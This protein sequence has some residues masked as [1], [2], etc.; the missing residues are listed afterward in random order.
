LNIR[1]A[2]VEN[3]PLA[4]GRAILRTN[5]TLTLYMAQRKLGPSL[6]ERL[7]ALGA[8]AL[9]LA[10]PA[11]FVADLSGLAGSRVR[12]DRVSA[13]EGLIARLT[14]AGAEVDVGAD[15]C[16]LAKACK[17]AAE[18][19]GIQAAHVR[20]GVAVVEFLKWFADTA[21]GGHTE[22]TVAEKL[23]ELRAAGTNYRG[24]S[25]TTISAFGPSSAL[26]HYRATRETAL[27]LAAGNVYLVDSG[28]QYLDGT[29]DITRVTVVGEPT[30]EMRARYTQVLRGHIALACAR[31]P[32]GTSGSQLDPFARQY[33]WQAGVDF[34][35]GTG[36]GV[37]C[38]LGVHEG[39]QNISKRPLQVPLR[40]G[41]VVSNEPGYYK[42]GHFGIRIENLVTVV[43][44][45]PQPEG[46]EKQTLGFETLTLAPYESRLIVVEQLTPEERTWVDA[47]HAR[48]RESLTPLV[49][50][51]TLPYLRAATE[52]L[53]A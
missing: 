50:P 10:A 49:A 17:T 52:P 27:P 22:W 34:D 14:S 33:L 18:L 32:A 35:H 2:D 28:G 31:F 37:G 42:A 19:R 46:A 20:D 3:T 8:G 47:Y 25:F 29:T 15:P 21:P 9:R 40:P 7:E 36:H 11:D 4:L 23:A 1:G 41:M 44:V 53:T 48:V 5:G 13:S 39:P 45:E 6:R 12:V 38:F 24:P 43:A 16:T 30:I 26:P 51:S